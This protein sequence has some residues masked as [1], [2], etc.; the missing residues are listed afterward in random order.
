MKK[1]ELEKEVFKN[2]NDKYDSYLTITDNGLDIEAN[3]VEANCITSKNNTFGIDSSGNITCNSITTNQSSI[4]F[5][6]IY[7]VGS[8]Y[9]SINDTNP[10]T[11]F[12]GTWEQIQDK[13]LVGAGN[14]YT[15]G[16]IGGTTT[17]THTSAAHSHT[18]AAHSHNYGSLYAAINFAGTYG[19]RYRTVANG[20]S[21]NERKADTGAGYSYG[22]WCS[23]AVCV[24]GDTGV[25]TPGDTGVT[26][27]GDTGSSSNIPPYLAVYIWKRTS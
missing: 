9:L 19:T 17:H 26:T 10:G 21:P 25:T 24:Y 2:M 13:F 3:N 27:P 14:N 5:N 11:L 15:L 1:Y 12:G 20:F 23:E 18:S 22:N 16:A 6:H 8:I 4:D 7:P